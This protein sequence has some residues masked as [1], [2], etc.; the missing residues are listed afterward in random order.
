[1]TDVER[2]AADQGGAGVGVRAGEDPGARAGFFHGDGPCPRI[3]EMAPVIWLSPVETPPSFSVR[4][5][6]GAVT[7]PES[8]S[9]PRAAGDER[10][11]RAEAEIDGAGDEVVSA[12]VVDAA[13]RGFAAGVEGD[14]V[15]DDDVGAVEPEGS[16]A[17]GDVDGFRAAAER[18][19]GRYQGC[20][21]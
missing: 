20:R 19:A 10:V 1:M 6:A 18:G 11:S 3:S 14:G 16:E 2:A 4:P 9:E 17:G 13:G 8:S 15:G 21:W 12:E 7:V 5:A